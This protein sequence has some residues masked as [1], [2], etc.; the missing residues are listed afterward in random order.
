MIEELEKRTR[1]YFDIEEGKDNPHSHLDYVEEQVRSGEPIASLARSI[2]QTLKKDIS[3]QMLSGYLH[4]TFP[5]ALERL[6]AAKPNMAEAFAED[7][8][9]IVDSAEGDKAEIY[10]AGLRARMRESL[11]K[12]FNPAFQANKQ[13]TMQLNVNNLHLTALTSIAP[14]SRA[15]VS[16]EQP[17][18][19]IGALMAGDKSESLSPTA[20]SNKHQAA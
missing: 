4:K 15:H 7:A 9:H 2:G 16:L 6:E 5:E 18:G 17:E 12:M 11:A 20:D 1:A 10:K 8:L 19:Q 3:R 14:Q 13:P